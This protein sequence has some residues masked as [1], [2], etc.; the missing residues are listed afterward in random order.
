M[1]FSGDTFHLIE[2]NVANTGAALLWYTELV[3]LQVT[4]TTMSFTEDLGQL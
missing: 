1:P 4:N 2:L 3:E